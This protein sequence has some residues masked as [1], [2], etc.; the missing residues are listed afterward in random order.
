VSHAE[1]GKPAISDPAQTRRIATSTD[2][3]A[4]RARALSLAGRWL[5][6]AALVAIALVLAWKF[7]ASPWLRA[8]GWWWLVAAPMLIA[9][10]PGA[11]ALARPVRPRRGAMTLDENLALKDRLTSAIDLH[12]R[13]PPGV[14]ASFAELAVRRAE[15]MARAVRPDDA[16]PIRVDRAWAVWPS[17]VVLA[18]GAGVFVRAR[19]P[20]VVVVPQVTKEEAKQASE[21]VRAAAKVIETIKSEPALASPDVQRQLD[22]IAEVERELAAGQTLPADA[23]T[24]SAKALERLAQ[25]LKDNADR[26]L[27]AQDALRDSLL[28]AGRAK[29]AGTPDAS[30]NGS[31]ELAGA[32]K[33]GD[34]AA[35]QDAARELL[36]RMPSM[37]ADERAALAK[38][39]RDLSSQMAKQD[40]ANPG[41][42]GSNAS[43][44]GTRDHDGDAAK[45]DQDNIR[46]NSRE[47]DSARADEPSTQGVPNTADLKS[48][49]PKGT[50]PANSET[51]TGTDNKPEN[52]KPDASTPDQ[53]TRN[54]TTP[55]DSKQ[56]AQN[57]APTSG[58]STPTGKK[59]DSAKPDPSAKPALPSGTPSE[60]TD[61]KQ[62]DAGERKPQNEQE[63]KD[64]PKPSTA[65]QRK[66][67]LRRAMEDAARDLADPDKP[68]DTDRREGESQRQPGQFSDQSRENRPS[69]SKSSENKSNESKPGEGASGDKNNREGTPRRSDS[70]QKQPTPADRANDSQRPPTT[71]SRPEPRPDARGERTNEPNVADHGEQ[72]SDSQ[73]GEANEPDATKP[74][75][76]KTDA[77]KPDESP[78][79]EKSPRPDSPGLQKLADT[80]RDAEE[81][82]KNA[83]RDS[84]LA[85]RLREQAMKTL[86]DASPEQIEKAAEAARELAKRAPKPDPNSV[87][88]ETTR[89]MLEQAEQLMKNATPEQKQKLQQLARKMAEG[90]PDNNNNKDE[91]ENTGDRKNG[92]EQS[93]DAARRAAEQ[94]MKNA[95]PE[96]KKQ[97]Q[98]LARSL[99]LDRP[100]PRGPRDG[101]GDQAG[102]GPGRDRGS[103]RAFG[104]A[105]EKT[106]DMRDR[107]KGE[108]PTP[109]DRVISDWFD[110]SG[111]PGERAAS[112]RSG[113][114]AEVVRRA[115]Q[116]AERSIEQQVVPPQQGDYVRR[117]F[118]RYLQRTQGVTPTPSAPATSPATPDAP[119]APRK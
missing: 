67:Q 8:I 80:L 13:T 60:K 11:F 81:A 6:G 14:D 99:G 69:E 43:S 3:R 66:E 85:D 112:G 16:V 40:A 93:Q 63:P 24:Q 21:Q 64:K 104:D 97:L 90:M 2:R 86:E 92:Q 111:K 91:G 7:V 9:A 5:S 29:D 46:D 50:E 79:G 70:P 59:A 4:I 115:A 94:F 77:G 38:E 98:D 18:I 101:P 118:R 51:P 96:E 32:L 116:G 68:R 28:S 82:Q 27:S 74:E 119:D 49:Q 89:R 54:E 48:N 117:V 61:T 108:A 26:E 110:P 35:A 53:S 71:E 34:L 45:N 88:P 100:N 23:R 107:S 22:A 84:K 41:D 87:S 42:S 105:E 114:G 95:S 72:K 73:A 33:R 37:S 106:V 109:D 102:D 103:P 20:S 52:A 56:D 39:L 12:D 19:P 15:E 76:S 55:E 113:S 83:S 57:P 30:S 78:H 75:A 44:G 10:A 36:E 25:S 1:P 47:A 31:S 58:Q 65:E 17:L 62:T